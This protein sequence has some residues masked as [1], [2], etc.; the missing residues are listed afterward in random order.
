MKTRRMNHPSLREERLRKRT[1]R[2]KP[3]PLA[4]PLTRNQATPILETSV[5]Q[6]PT[7]SASEA[8]QQQFQAQSSENASQ[9]AGSDKKN[10]KRDLEELYTNIRSEPNYSAKIKEFLQAY[11]L[12][13]KNKRIVKRRFPRRRVI[14]RFPFDVWMGDLIEFPGLKFY[15][16]H[17]KYALLVIDVFTKVIYIEPMKRKLGADCAE[18]FEK[19][20]S[21]T[22]SPPVMLITDRGKE[23]YNSHFNNVMFNNGIN[24]FSTPT[25][26]KFKASVA[27][28]AIRTIKT[29][30]DRYMQ[31]TKSKNWV[32]VIRDFVDGYNNT[33]HSAHK[34]KPLDVSQDNKN[35]V[36]KRLY[37][38]EKTA[39][40]CKLKVGD[41][42]R[43][44]R[45]KREYE[46]GYTQN[47]S[48]QV[49]QIVKV[50]QKHSVCWY[51]L[52]DASGTVLNQIFYYYQLN[53]VSRNAD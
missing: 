29:K 37:P 13:S 36:Y 52:S 1:T 12:H 17:F 22:K 40:E 39:V 48:D 35:L 6:S 23:F 51:K 44:L 50:L 47:W 34:L 5:G 11:D 49:Y 32:D 26:T 25:P 16:K 9:E 46:K 19:I 15:N 21:K 41:R 7:E 3:P 10:L 4:Q 45:S 20:L 33:P 53:L 31:H 14:A 27:E 24:H 28:R 43:T 18:A 38:K 42:V 8:K 30:I 2:Q